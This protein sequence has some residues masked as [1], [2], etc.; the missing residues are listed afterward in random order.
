MVTSGYA[1]VATVRQRELPTRIGLALF[2]T[3]EGWSFPTP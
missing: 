3:E 1:A 2:M